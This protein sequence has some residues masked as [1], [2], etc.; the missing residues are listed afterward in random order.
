MK[1]D[2][3]CKPTAALGL[4]M[5]YRTIHKSCI[6]FKNND[7]DE[8]SMTQEDLRARMQHVE[9]MVIYMNMHRICQFLGR[10]GNLVIK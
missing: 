8:L 5:I 6:V 9:D 10:K 4:H 2:L 7:G 1:K 3:L